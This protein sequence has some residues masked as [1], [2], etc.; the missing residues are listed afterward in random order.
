MSNGPSCRNGQS[1]LSGIVFPLRETTIFPIAF[2][3]KIVIRRCKNR[4][5]KA[6]GHWQDLAPLPV[7]LRYTSKEQFLNYKSARKH[8]VH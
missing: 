7:D 6:S 8:H 2:P 1:G 5:P 3:S 4:H